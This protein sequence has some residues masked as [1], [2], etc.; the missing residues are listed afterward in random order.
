[1]SISFSSSLMLSPLPFAMKPSLVIR[2][3]VRKWRRF[4]LVTTANHEADVIRSDNSRW[5]TVERKSLASTRNRFFLKVWNYDLIPLFWNGQTGIFIIFFFFLFIYFYLFKVFTKNQALG[6][7]PIVEGKVFTWLVK[8]PF[9][10][11]WNVIQNTPPSSLDHPGGKACFCTLSRARTARVLS[12]LLHCCF[13]MQKQE[14]TLQ[15]L[16]DPRLIVCEKG[17]KKPSSS[18]WGLELRQAK[19]LISGGRVT[20]LRVWWEMRAGRGCIW[21]QVTV[22]IRHILGCTL[23]NVCPF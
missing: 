5:M 23:S 13:N 14:S 21:Y 2:A 11:P 9:I 12:I 1:M 17:W 10:F 22:F 20:G 19:T 15:R 3:R 18:T 16:L 8:G 6:R 4:E 7:I